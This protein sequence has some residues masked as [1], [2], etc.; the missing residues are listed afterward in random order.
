MS[1]LAAAALAGVLGGCS[2]GGGVSPVA[3]SPVA[4]ADKAGP[5]V[6]TLLGTATGV[7]FVGDWTS[8]GCPGRTYAR[9]L[10]F[11]PDQRWQAIDLVSPCPPGTECLWSG[12]TTYGGIWVQKGTDLHLRE[13]GG[14]TQ[15]G[16][17]HPTLVNA[18]TEGTLVENG[19]SYGKGLTVPS[20]YTEEQV[21][22]VVPR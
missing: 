13:V 9:N 21:R 6:E 12:L 19:C 17:P 7:A 5:K 22:P 15:P 16:S 18:T 11:E 1:L 14:Y 3:A 20:G 2:G 8:T 10:R 4:D